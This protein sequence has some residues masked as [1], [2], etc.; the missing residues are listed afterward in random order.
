MFRTTKWMCRLGTFTSFRFKILLLLTTASLFVTL[1][2][3]TKSGSSL[4]LLKSGNLCPASSSSVPPTNARSAISDHQ[5][6]TSRSLDPNSTRRATTAKLTASSSSHSPKSAE[7][8]DKQFSYAVS[9]SSKTD[10]VQLN[11]TTLKAAV[12]S[13]RTLSPQH[14]TIASGHYII[15][16]LQ[17]VP[18][19]VEQ[20]ICN[21]ETAQQEIDALCQL[22]RSGGVAGSLCS[23]LCDQKLIRLDDWCGNGW[24]KKVVVLPADLCINL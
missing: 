13:S 24:Q 2:M 21:A 17:K 8:D 11:A 23:P 14:R 12:N 3:K 10:S 4:I 1:V 18:R 16:M 15:H 20:W 5:R 9:H 6:S 19:K 22:Y 7:S